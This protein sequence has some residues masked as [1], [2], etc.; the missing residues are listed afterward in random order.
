MR[1]RVQ[2]TNLAVVCAASSFQLFADRT[3]RGPNWSINS[4][5][6]IIKNSIET[7]AFLYNVNKKHYEEMV[8]DGMDFYNRYLKNVLETI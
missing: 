5:P 2:R 4:M 1:T 7:Q 8:T 3:M 6:N